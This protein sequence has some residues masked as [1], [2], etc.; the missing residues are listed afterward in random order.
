[1]RFF[2]ESAW[3]YVMIDDRLCFKDGSFVYGHT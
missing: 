2:K 3:R 1:M